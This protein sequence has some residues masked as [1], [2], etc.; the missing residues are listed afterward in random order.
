MAFDCCNASSVV[1]PTHASLS[2]TRKWSRDN[3]LVFQRPEN[4]VLTRSASIAES[5]MVTVTESYFLE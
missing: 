4:T 3:T 1:A 2:G 5:R